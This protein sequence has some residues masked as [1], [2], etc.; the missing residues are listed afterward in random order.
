MRINRHQEVRRSV[1]MNPRILK[2]STRYEWTVATFDHF[3]SRKGTYDLTCRKMINFLSI[4]G[5]IALVD[6]RPFF[7]VLIYTQSVGLLGRE[8]SSSQGL[9]LHR[10]Q[11]K[12]NKPTHISMP[13]VGFEPKIP[14]FERAKA[15]HA[16]GRAATV[17]GLIYFRCCIIGIHNIL[18]HLA[19]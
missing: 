16:L 14:A 10:E 12:H 5:S 2:V 4:Y 3:I 1:G 19:Y 7:S 8:I 9:Y 15:V 17:T 6:F 18:C 13:R 11:H